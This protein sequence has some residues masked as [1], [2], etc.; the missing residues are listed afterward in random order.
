M[1]TCYGAVTGRQTS[2]AETAFS[3]NVQEANV[4]LKSLM[5][6]SA[7]GFGFNNDRFHGLSHASSPT[8]H[9]PGAQGGCGREDEELRCERRTIKGTAEP[10]TTP[11]DSRDKR[12]DLTN[13]NRKTQIQRAE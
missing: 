4:V 7:V 2:P 13:Q 9:T 6:S 12:T 10:E 11:T 1:Y 5:L 8:I 3:T